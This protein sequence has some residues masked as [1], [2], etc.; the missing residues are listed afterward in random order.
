MIF[1]FGSSVTY[2]TTGKADL[3]SM[4]AGLLILLFILSLLLV[5]IRRFLKKPSFAFLHIYN[6]V[7]AIV[8]S[9]GVCYL[10]IAY[11]NLSQVWYVLYLPLWLILY[12]LWELSYESKSN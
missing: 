9:I 12:G 2:F 6:G 4:V 11:Y 8:F 1:L 7:F 10:S 3:L 5:V